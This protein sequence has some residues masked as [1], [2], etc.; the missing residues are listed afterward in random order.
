MSGAVFTEDMRSTH[1]IILPEMLEYHFP[2]LKAALNIGGYKCEILSNNGKSV[3]N[4]G[5]SYAHNDMCF[6]AIAIIGQMIDALKSGLCDPEKIAFMLPQAGGACRAGNYFHL[7]KKALEKA[8]YKNVPVISLNLNGINSQPGFKITLPM[9]KAAVYSV[10]CGDLLMHLYQQ[11]KPYEN[12]KDETDLLLEYWQK[13]LYQKI[14]NGISRHKLKAQFYNILND[15][16]AVKITKTN[17]K[18]I[19]IAG[20]LYVKYCKIGNLGLEDFLLKNNCEYRMTGFSIYALYNVESILYDNKSSELLKKGARIVLKLLKTLYDDLA[21]AVSEYSDF[22]PMPYYSEFSDKNALSKE[23]ISGDGWLI[24]AESAVLIENGYKNIILLNP[25]G[26]LVS[27]INCK[28]IASAIRNNYDNAS[29]TSIE[30]DSDTSTA[31]FHS[32]VHM[33]IGI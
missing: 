30:C 1:T 8:G 33:A 14:S 20:E 27:H 19:G 3:I 16:S 9:I 24:S 25:F 6:P 15:F 31:L 2:I 32:R 12:N 29:V 7:L 5:K 4:T 11:I 13:K 26:C 28:G 10:L 17:C 23:C 22:S 21:K 18:K